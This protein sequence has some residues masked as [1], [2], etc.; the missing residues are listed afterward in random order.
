MRPRVRTRYVAVFHRIVVDVIEMPNTV[1]FVADGM[2]PEPT[3]PDTAGSLA[4]AGV[5][6]RLF[7][8]TGGEEGSR[9]C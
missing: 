2:F 4:E 9:E 6:T 7:V 1:G 8:A 3:L 5:G